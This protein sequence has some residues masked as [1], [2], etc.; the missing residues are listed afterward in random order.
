MGQTIWP[1]RGTH[2]LPSSVLILQSTG[3]QRVCNTYKYSVCSVTG[4]RAV[5]VTCKALPLKAGQQYLE[6]PGVGEICSLGTKLYNSLWGG[7]LYTY[8]HLLLDASIYSD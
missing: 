1:Y 3:L 5:G 6:T 2:L 8:Y 7:G 4:C